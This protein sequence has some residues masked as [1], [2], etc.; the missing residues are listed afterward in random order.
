MIEFSNL[1]LTQPHLHNEWRGWADRIAVLFSQLNEELRS[2]F[3][4]AITKAEVDSAISA[5]LAS[6]YTKTEADALYLRKANNLSDLADIAAANINLGMGL[7][8]ISSGTI[9]VPIAAIDV[10]LPNPFKTFFLST[11]KLHGAIDMQLLARVSQDGGTT[12]PATASHHWQL[13]ANYTTAPTGSFLDA[14]DGSAFNHIVLDNFLHKSVGNWPT[15]TTIDIWPGDAQ[16][17]PIVHYHR[18]GYR[19]GA[20]LTTSHGSGAYLGAFGRAT[21][22]RIFPHANNLVSGEWELYGR[23]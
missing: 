9:T 20:L 19:D 1:D 23:R 12:F 21:H 6:Y 8:R 7:E 17:Y 11:R 16:S 5:A 3:G 13:Y 14:A 2:R 4:E 18:T 15:W 10:A 22:L